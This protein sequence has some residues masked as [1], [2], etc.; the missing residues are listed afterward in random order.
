LKKWNADEQDFINHKDFHPVRGVVS[1]GAGTQRGSFDERSENRLLPL[2]DFALV[3]KIISG[4]LR[5]S[6][7]YYKAKKE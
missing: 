5:K 1:N 2:G 4:N 6:A 7:S 3:P